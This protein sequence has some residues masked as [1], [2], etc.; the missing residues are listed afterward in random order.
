M[1]PL[2]SVGWGKIHPQGLT[3]KGPA[4]AIDKRESG[5]WRAR[6][7]GPDRRERSRTFARKGDAERWLRAQETAVA[8]GTWL[9]PGRGALTVA[10]WADVWLPTR[11][12]DL[13]PTTWERTEQ[14]VRVHIVPKWGTRRLSS[15]TNSEVAAWAAW[16]QADGGAGVSPR[17]ARKV[18]MVFRAM[19]A[20]A[21]A[22]RRISLN[23]VDAVPLPSDAGAEREWMTQEQASALLE[24]MP[25]RYRVA[26]LL[27]YYAG[28]RWGELAGLR[29]RDVDV[30]RNRVTVARTASMVGGQVTY[31]PPKTRAG[32]RTLPVARS[33]MA[34]VA[35]HL[36]QHVRPGPDALVLANRDGGPVLRPNFTRRV[37][38]PALAAA[39]LPSTLTPHA[40]RHGYAS[41]LIG[42]RFSIKEVSTWCG[43]SSVAVT[44]SIYA[45]VAELEGDDAA[46]RLDA[47]LIPARPGGEVHPIRSLRG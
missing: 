18:L 1:V 43:H 10:G 40:M 7:R 23:P 28:L 39:G 31:G 21:V 3:G 16:L 26:V 45:H 9:D 11:R 27:G 35:D 19:M 8:E 33:I 44:L 2:Y 24:V 12:A 36:A 6:Y 15:I 4:V 42:A 46:D 37:W 20:A 38:R 34:Q 25:A 29:R 41:W 30:L 32:Q 47:A 22:D 14:V 13:R 5:S 17:T